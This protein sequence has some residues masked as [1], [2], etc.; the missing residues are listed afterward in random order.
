MDIKLY[1]FL[2]YVMRKL[3]KSEHASFFLHAV[4]PNIY[5]DYLTAVTHPMDLNTLD[6]LVSSFQTVETFLFEASF[7]WENCRK[8]NF[9]D[10]SIA[11]N[12]ELLHNLL[13]NLIN[14]CINFIKY[15]KNSHY[16]SS[17]F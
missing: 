9:N 14:V 10:T 3:I 1:T 4:D 2:K 6:G 16:N 7:I 17:L 5:S 13:R 8:Y 12:A 11:Q 15:H